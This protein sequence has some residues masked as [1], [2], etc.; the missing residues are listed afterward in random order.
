MFCLNKDALI[1]LKEEKQIIKDK[2][3]KEVLTRKISKIPQIN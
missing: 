3:K 2:G 1:S